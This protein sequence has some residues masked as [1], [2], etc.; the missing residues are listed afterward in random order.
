MSAFETEVLVEAIPLLEL[1][2]GHELS[3]QG[4]RLSHISLPKPGNPTLEMAH[5]GLCT[6][7]PWQRASYLFDHGKRSR[8]NQDEPM[9]LTATH[10]VA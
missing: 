8:N 7:P 4:R 1:V 9:T 2:Q 3:L 5:T 10:K 6:V